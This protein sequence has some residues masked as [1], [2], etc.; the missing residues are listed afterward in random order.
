MAD[1]AL[2][3]DVSQEFRSVLA[4]CDDQ[5]C[6][7]PRRLPQVPPLTE[8]DMVQLRIRVVALENVVIAL[9]AEASDRQLELVRAMAA[10]ISPRPG[11]TQHPLSLHAAAHMVDLVERADHFSAMIKGNA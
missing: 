5:E 8:A 6:V 4:G 11:F 9:M 2:Y 1:K 7:E 3:L 10:Y